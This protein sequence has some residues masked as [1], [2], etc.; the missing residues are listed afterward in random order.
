[1]RQHTSPLP[2][3]GSGLSPTNVSPPSLVHANTSSLIGARPSSRLPTAAAATGLGQ[4]PDVDGDWS[5]EEECASPSPTSIHSSSSSRESLHHSSM[6]PNHQ[7]LTPP[8]PHTGAYYHRSHHHPSHL[9]PDTPPS[10][11][12]FNLE[13]ASQYCR[14]QVGY[15]SFGDI[16]GLGRPAAEEEEERLERLRLTREGEGGK[17]KW[18]WGLFTAAVG[19]PGAAGGPSEEAAARTGAI[20]GGRGGSDV[21]VRRP[22]TPGVA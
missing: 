14:Q 13:S 21:G 20:V 22:K 11:S 1:M 15:V 12:T 18:L 10:S 16:E 4:T 8:H 5:Y 6:S 2:L 9:L 3:S 19:V 7:P 17:G